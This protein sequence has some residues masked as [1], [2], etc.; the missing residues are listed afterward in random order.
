MKHLLTIGFLLLSVALAAQDNNHLQEIVDFYY[1]DMVFSN[2]KKTDT[3]DL[4]EDAIVKLERLSKHGLFARGIAQRALAQLEPYRAPQKEDPADKLTEKLNNRMAEIEQVYTAHSTQ[5]AEGLLWCAHVCTKYK[6]DQQC[7]RL[8]EQSERLFRQCGNGIFN[9]RDTITEIFRLD[10]L[11]QLEY[12]SERDFVAVQYA[13]K[14]CELKKLYFGEENEVYFNALL[15]LSNLYAERERYRKSNHYHNLG[16]NAYVERIKKEFCSTSESERVAFWEKAKVY[17]NKTISIAHKMSASSHIG[18]SNSLASAAYN[19]LLLSKGL[20]LNTS[21]SFEDYIYTSGNAEAIRLLQQKK[22]LSGMHVPQNTLD[23]LDY[24]ILDA[25]KR[26]GQTFELPH[27]SIRWED[28]AAKLEP[29][30]LAIEFYRTENDAYGAILLKK[31]W[32]SPKVIPLEKNRSSEQQSK[33]KRNKQPKNSLSSLINALHLE[34]YHPEDA[35]KIWHLGKAIWTDEIVQYFPVNGDGRIFFAADGVMQITGIEYLPFVKPQKEGGYYCLSDLFPMY[36]LSSTRE[37]VLENAELTNTRVAV[38]GGLQYW[39]EYAQLKA[40]AT[41]YPEYRQPLLAYNAADTHRDLSNTSYIMPLKGAMKE[42]DSIVA[43]IHNAPQHPFEVRSYK[44]PQGTEASFKALQ[45]E[46]PRLI[47]VATHGFFMNEDDAKNKKTIAH[48]NPMTRSGLLLAGAESP[49][50]GRPFPQDVEDGI[51]TAAE[52]ANMNLR[53]LEMVVLSACETGIGDIWAD[54]VFGL[55]R[56]FKMAGT[57]SILM[58]L[59]KVDDDATTVLM[60]EFYRKWMEG[61]DKHDALN[62]AR[63]KVR[64][65]PKWNNPKYWAAFILLDGIE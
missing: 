55:Q 44:G 56:G 30:D 13:E 33:K 49:W 60:T 16:Y 31:D 9:G 51:L 47:H 54:G 63:A 65:N 34:Q 39:M 22:I 64:Q 37:L 14:A 15:N 46:H 35:S 29:N 2:P 26:Q 41:H 42:A 28:V 50:F 48:E 19:A 8:L 40:D 23:S 10:V 36:R 25:L 20:L 18:G 53:G 24:A 61:T 11:A 45:N 59:W 62:A 4:I 7:H 6:D 38:Y 57:G 21:N 27:L 52:I 58:S 17:I 5:Y 1:Q 32:T 3:V 12:Q 43:I